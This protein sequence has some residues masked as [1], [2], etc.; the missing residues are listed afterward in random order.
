MRPARAVTGRTV[1]AACAQPFFSVDDWFIGTT[2]MS[3][4]IP[5]QPTVRFPYG[6]LAALEQVLTERTVACVVMEAATA[7]G[8]PPPGYLAGV[9]QLCDRYGTLLVFDEM[10]TGFRWAAGGA[11]Q[12]Y[13]VVPDLS[14]WGKAMGNGFPISALAGGR[15]YLELGGLRTADPRVFLLS[16]THG[17]ETG[18][19]AAFRAVVYAYATTDPITRMEH[20][21]RRLRAGSRRSPAPKPPSWAPCPPRC[22]SICTA[23]VTRCSCPASR[24]SA[25]FR[26]K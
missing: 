23:A 21:G 14:C 11:Q 22:W 5:E 1:V 9:R 4:G 17:P 2:E 20:A 24:I 12:V 13:G 25:S 26:W 19:L 3:A 6:D 18:G 10:I 8:E 7:L 16:T 15:E